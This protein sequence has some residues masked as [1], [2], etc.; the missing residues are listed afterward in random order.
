[1]Y[2]YIYIILYIK[3]RLCIF[4]F[5]SLLCQVFDLKDKSCSLTPDDSWQLSAPARG[6]SS[7]SSQSSQSSQSALGLAKL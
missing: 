1:M 3:Y 2:V 4:L 6:Q 5:S 7:P